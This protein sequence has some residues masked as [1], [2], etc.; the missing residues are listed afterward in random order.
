MIG[1]FCSISGT[2]IG[3]SPCYTMLCS[4]KSVKKLNR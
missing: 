4:E 2:D 1:T 3:T